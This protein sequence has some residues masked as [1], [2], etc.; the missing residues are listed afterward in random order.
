[1]DKVLAALAPVFVLI[2][3][4]WGARAF[5]LASAEQ[6]G[7]VNRLG[8]FIFYPAFLFTTITGSPLDLLRS[9]AFLGGVVGGFA[10]VMA[11]SLTLRAVITDGPAFTSVFQGA[12]RWNGFALLAAANDLYGPHGRD[13]V[14]L[15][16][17][18]LV[19]TI[20]LVCVAVMARWGE[21]R[22]GSWRAIIDQI[23]ANPLILACA[24]G[25]SAKLIG[26]TAPAMAMDALRLLAAAAM[27]IALICVGAGL[28][29]S[30][31][32]ASR[33]LVA[34]GTGLRLLAAPALAYATTTLL[35]APPLQAAIAAGIASTPTAAAAY[36]L[37]REMGGDADLMAAII[38][39]T[40]LFSFI[41]MPIV[42]A[43]AAP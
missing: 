2:L 14:A 21:G 22:G 1:M 41:T 12:V 19:L 15:A 11:L 7:A 9:G 34:A 5:R 8:Y 4:G 29:L 17:G 40:T 36:V 33:A 32:R 27:P 43:L 42:I 38:T 6:F 18:P 20:N 31:M 35:G 26:W 28:N 3:V 37:A 39:A 23:A 30:A 16:F 10:A 13:W 25:L 24:A